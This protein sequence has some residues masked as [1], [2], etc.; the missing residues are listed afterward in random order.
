MNRSRAT[1]TS[2]YGWDSLFRLIVAHMPQANAP[3]RDH[4]ISPKSPDP[5]RQP[6]A[7]LPVQQQYRWLGCLTELLCVE[8]S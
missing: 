7:L 5:E 1:A 6:A 2:N 8:R 4:A 3:Q